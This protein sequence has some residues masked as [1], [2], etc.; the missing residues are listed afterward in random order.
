MSINIC[1]IIP[2]N[3]NSDISNN[4]EKAIAHLNKK[5]KAESISFTDRG[6][7]SF[8]DCGENLERITCPICNADLPFD[9]WSEAMDVCY[10]NGFSDLSVTLHCCSKT[11]SLND[12]IY[13]F[14][15]G[16]AKQEIT[17][18]EP[19]AIPDDLTV[20]EIESIL[21]EK[22]RIIICRY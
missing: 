20:K 19:S 10:E 18:T 2:E 11:S 3:P 16:F 12:L 13:D 21:G 17:I 15:C 5:L 14:P 8:I 22:V 4:S 6:Q 7:I 1:K 9:W